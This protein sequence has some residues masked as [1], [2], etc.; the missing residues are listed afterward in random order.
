MPV[1][2]GGD[3][4]G[5]PL[6]GTLISLLHNGRP[7]LGI[8]NIPVL[9]ERWVGAIG[10]PTTLNGEILKSHQQGISRTLFAHK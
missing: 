3:D 9:K 4:A 7:I 1:S 6:F 10:K 8:I 2:E 5:N